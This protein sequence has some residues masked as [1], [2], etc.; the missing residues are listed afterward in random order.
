MGKSEHTVQE[1]LRQAENSQNIE[2][3]ERP[4][5]LGG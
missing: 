3:K 4:T 1:P 5:G 2:H